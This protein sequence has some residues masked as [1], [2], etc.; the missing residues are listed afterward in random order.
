MVM[1]TRIQNI[2]WQARARAFVEIVED[3]KAR[4]G[5]YDCIVPVSGGKDS[6]YQVIKARDYGLNVL[7]VTWKTPA[8]TEIGQRNLD[9]M[10]AN[11]GVD[12]IDYTIN[13]DVER[14]LHE[15]RL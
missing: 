11:L 12:H 1:M 6:W 15:G 8:R 13:P 3:A 9:D 4:S 5:G 2:D 14:P 10:V 7:A